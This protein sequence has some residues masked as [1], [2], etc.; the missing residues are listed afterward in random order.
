MSSA[1]S[2]PATTS[3][4]S[5]VVASPSA[6]AAARVVFDTATI[7]DKFALPMTI[8]VPDGWRPLT[9][10]PGVLTM[11]HVGS[12]PKS[13]S[14]WWGPDTPSSTARVSDPGLI[15]QPAAKGDAKAC[16]GRPTS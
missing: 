12:P 8:D 15:L 1:P 13:Q 2:A 6:T 7:P 9:D 10:V 11:V 14:E 16:H 4:A 3:R 5:A